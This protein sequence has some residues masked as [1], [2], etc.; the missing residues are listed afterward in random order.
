MSELDEL[1]QEVIVDHFKNPRCFGSLDDSNTSAN[2]YNPLCGDQINVCVKIEDSKIKKIAFSGKGCSI[3]QAAASMMC[4][5][6]EGKDIETAEALFELYQ[7][8]L[9]GEKREE[10]LEKLGDL[11]SLSGVRKFSARI[12]CAMLG[13]EAVKRALVDYK[14]G[15]YKK[16]NCEHCG[17]EC[18]EKFNENIK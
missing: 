9:K 18:N 17:K 11:T 7:N 10:E 3:S 1:Y 12:K 8:M 6:L 4:E 14:S 15:H 16:P 5:L 2:L 13:W